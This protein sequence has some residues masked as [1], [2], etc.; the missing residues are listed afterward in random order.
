MSS[1]N[2]LKQII[3][4]A[5]LAA[6]GPL[7]LDNMLELFNEEER[8]DK[9]DLRQVIAELQ[10][11]YENRGMELVEVGGGFRIN[12]RAA[13]APWVSRLWEERPARYSRA[14]LE[15]LALVAY[16]QPITRSEIEEIRGVSV[17]TNIMKTLLEREWVRVV[18][19]RDVPGRPS[20]Y[21]TTREFLNYF[22][23]KG[24]D[25]LPTLQEIRDLDSI[26]QEL[27]FEETGVNQDSPDSSP[28]T[29]KD[30]VADEETIPVDVSLANSQEA[31]ADLLPDGDDGLTEEA[32][33][34]AAAGIDEHPPMSDSEPEDADLKDFSEGE[35]DE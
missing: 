25:D 34:S 24:L 13:Y 32:Q 30:Q 21:A 17:S 26:N 29:D 1:D 10:S 22:G 4:A 12:V 2:K 16:R 5:L 8:S 31:D 15:T 3:E 19:Q 23:L 33:Q 28:D 7:S 9:S 11:D 27:I 35:K 18:G 20:L 6:G 14:L